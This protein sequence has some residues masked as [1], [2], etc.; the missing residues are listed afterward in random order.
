MSIYLKDFTFPTDEQETK[1]LWPPSLTPDEVRRCVKRDYRA[2]NHNKS[3][4]PFQILSKY[5][6]QKLFFSDITILFGENGCGKSTA[7]NVMAEKLGLKRETRYNSGRF[8]PDYLEMCNY[9][10]KRNQDDNYRMTY[11]ENFEMQVPEGSRIITS[12][13]VFSL[14]LKTREYNSEYVQINEL[15]EKELKNREYESNIDRILAE[16]SI[17]AELK[18]NM[19]TEKQEYSNGQKAIDFF[20]NSTENNALYIL[21]EPENSLSIDSQIQLSKY[22]ES[23]SKYS[24]FIIATH[25]PIIAGL[26]NAKIYSFEEYKLVNRKWQE[27]EGIKEMYDYFQLR[28]QLFR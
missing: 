17:R 16:K 1:F 7:L 18:K 20:I 6:C 3:I 8:F 13:D 21:D 4:Y 12:D 24:Q 2:R 28:R 9:N 11:H 19:L 14:I 5:N 27:L 15:L 26:A 25:S 10:L 23:V 22:I